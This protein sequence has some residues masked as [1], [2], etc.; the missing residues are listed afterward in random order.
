MHS[1][2]R[3]RAEVVANIKYCCTTDREQPNSAGE[4]EKTP[5]QGGNRRPSRC[6]YVLW[7]LCVAGSKILYA[8]NVHTGG[9]AVQKKNRLKNDSG[10]DRESVDATT[11]ATDRTTTT[12]LF[13]VIVF[14]PASGLDATA[15]IFTTD[16]N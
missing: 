15:T 2:D 7:P 13:C 3:P 9:M 16:N 5:V 6:P 10:T 4:S 1:D 12:V 14:V 11:P 8:V